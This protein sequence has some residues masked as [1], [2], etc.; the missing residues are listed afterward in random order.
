MSVFFFRPLPWEYGIRNLIRRPA[1]TLLTLAALTVA[2]LLVLVVVA[3]VRGLESSLSVSG[4]ADVA[5]VHSLGT[6]ENMEYSSVAAS[7]AD[8]LAASVPGIG[9]N[10]GSKFVSAEL[11]LGTQATSA[12]HPAPSMALVRGV[13]LSALYVRPAVQIVDGHWPNPGEVLVGRLAGSKLGWDRQELE[14]GRMLN[15]EGRRWRVS[16]HFAAQGAVF[17]SEMWCPLPDLQQAMKRQDVSVIAVRLAPAGRFADL[18]LFCKERKQLEIEVVREQSYYELLH[19][20]YR[21]V[22]TMS[23]LVVAMVSGAG[24][25]A[26]WNAM[27]AAVVGRVRELATLQTLGFLRRAIAL[28]LVEEA[29]VLGAAA[30][31]LAAW[32]ALLL[33]NGQ[34]VRFTMGAFALRVDAVALLIGCGVSLLLGIAGALP[35]AVRA[36]RMPVVEGLKAV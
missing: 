9:Q 18:D 26:G 30:A 2:V 28:S 10:Y 25:F 7:T 6:T 15:F 14:I 16:G 32:A 13:G 21:P 20:H 4:R 22:R 35:A 12:S 23:W 8:L 34:A 36:M 5:L 1:R 3:F 33:V 31:I 11:Y 24:L 27:Y 17:E 29:A 19:R